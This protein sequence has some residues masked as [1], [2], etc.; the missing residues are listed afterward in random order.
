MRTFELTY[1]ITALANTIACKL[2]PNELAL[3]ASIFV[4]LGDTIA[5]I[6]AQQALCEEETE[7]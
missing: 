3:V 6:A 7:K 5:T 2:T 4:Q 1:A